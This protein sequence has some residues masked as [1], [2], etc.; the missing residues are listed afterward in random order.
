MAGNVD[1]ALEKRLAEL[2]RIG[3]S[4]SGFSATD[5]IWLIG[6]GVVGPALLLVWGWPS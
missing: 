5:W 4:E 2:E 6:L 3:S 1:S